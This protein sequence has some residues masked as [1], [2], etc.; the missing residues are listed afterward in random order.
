MHDDHT[1]HH[2]WTTRAHARRH[3]LSVGL[4]TLVGLVGARSL[5]SRQAPQPATTQNVV[6]ASGGPMPMPMA[7]VVGEVD[8]GR[9]GFNPSEILTDFDAGEV[10]T[11][12]NGQTVHTYRLVAAA[13]PVEIAPGVMYPAWTYNG[14]IPG[15]TIRVRQ[16]DRVRIAF[17]NTTDH[18]HGLHFHGIHPG[19]MDGAMAQVPPGGTFT[20][21][22][23]AE[24]FGVHLYHCHASPLAEHLARVDCTVSSTMA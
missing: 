2:G 22:F 4:G 7:D 5:P 6:P 18:A 11:L 19:S 20:Y 9:N 8:H 23:D 15:P 1:S 17:S 12:P 13:K 14:R 3:A 21:E 10:G 24:P 16:G